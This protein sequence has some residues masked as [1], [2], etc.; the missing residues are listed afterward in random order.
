MNGVPPRVQMAFSG[1]FGVMQAADESV[2]CCRPRGAG[3]AERRFRAIKDQ[4]QDPH[5]ALRTRG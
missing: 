1:P 2:A 4:D 3:W 5:V